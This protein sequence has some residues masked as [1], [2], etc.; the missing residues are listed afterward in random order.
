M[1]AK[2][3]NRKQLDRKGLHGESIKSQLTIDEHEEFAPR[4]PTIS[5]DIQTD[6]HDNQCNHGSENGKSKFGIKSSYKCK[7]TQK[8]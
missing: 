3:S 2:P 1:T 4:V 8:L 6:T 5:C 7:N